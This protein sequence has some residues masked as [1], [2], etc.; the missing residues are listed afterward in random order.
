MFKIFFLYHSYKK[1]DFQKINGLKTER[2]NSH[3]V[4]NGDNNHGMK[5]NEGFPSSP[6]FP[7]LR[8]FA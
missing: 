3:V 1:N 6:V 4:S 2:C 8:I 7:S 5:E